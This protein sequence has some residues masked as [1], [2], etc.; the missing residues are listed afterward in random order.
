MDAPSVLA[1]TFGFAGGSSGNCIWGFLGNPVRDETGDTRL[2]G[3][4]G[5]LIVSR[6][7]ARLIPADGAAEEYRVEPTDTGH[8]NMF[9]NFHDALVHDEPFGAAVARSFLNMLVV[10]RALES[11]ERGQPVEV[12]DPGGLPSTGGVPLWRP[13]GAGELF[14]GLSCQVK[15]DLL[16]RE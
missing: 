7:L 13:R 3:S 2:Y 4:H 10:L 11:A 16:T 12:A 8:Y 9:L 5:T 14:E 6:G 1:M 15:R